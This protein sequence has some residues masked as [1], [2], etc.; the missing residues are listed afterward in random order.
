MTINALLISPVSVGVASGLLG[1]LLGATISRLIRPASERVRGAALMAGGITIVA[2]LVIGIVL[3]PPVIVSWDQG[4]VKLPITNRIVATAAARQ[5]LLFAAGGLI[6]I[7][8]LVFTFQRDRVGRSSADRDRD[9]NLT[10]RFSEAITQ[11]G[12][13]S[14][15]IRLGAVYA[16]E[17]IAADSARDR[18]PIL[19]I[20]AAFVRESSLPTV[21]ARDPLV[22]PGADVL[23]AASA[24]G[25]TTQLSA[26][27]KPV[28]L[29]FTD[30]RDV[31]MRGADLRDS[32]L[33]GVNFIG[34]HLEGVDFT[35][36]MIHGAQF[37]GAF[38]DKATFDRASLY[39]SVLDHARLIGASLRETRLEAAS[40][41]STTLADANLTGATHLDSAHWGIE[42]VWP[43][44]FSPPAS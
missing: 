34:A 35:G 4:T 12:D 18:Q 32:T 41:V 8:T 44:G 26:P 13:P 31:D 6:A 40:L 36:A 42:T 28:N 39:A 33:H 19:D 7:V 16:L 37:N 10:K 38:L 15:T 9:A 23:A 1:L 20:L 2:L 17:R 3:L 43:A 30:L 11:L 5:A 27:T 22:L 24:I 14:S 21:P 25:R 29:A